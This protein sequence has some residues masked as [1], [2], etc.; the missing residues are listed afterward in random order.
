MLFHDFCEGDVRE[1]LLLRI[2]HFLLLNQVVVLSH[3]FCVDQ[4]PCMVLVSVC[5]IRHE[6]SIVLEGL[7]SMLPVLVLP[8]S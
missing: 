5:E 6:F 8:L 2:L 4:F 7:I 1:L 3:C